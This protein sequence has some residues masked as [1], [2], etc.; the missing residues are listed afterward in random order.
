MRARAHLLRY[1][2]NKALKNK[3]LLIK[4]FIV[5]TL[6]LAGFTLGHNFLHIATGTTALAGAALLMFLDGFGH[7]HT[8]RNKKAHEAFHQVEWD[9]IFFFLGLFV[10][11]ASLEHT[12]LLAL[13]AGQITSFTE[14]D[15]TKT[16][17]TI[18]WASTFFSAF[19]NNI[20]FVATL[21]PIIESMGDTFGHGDALNPLWWSLVLG[22]CLGGNGTLIGA[23]ANVMVASFA[24]RS[25]NPISFMKY[26]VYGL[27]LTILTII[28]ANIYLMIM[29]F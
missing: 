16:G 28:I 14:G 8:E 9:T 29:Y 4:S 12:G 18:L 22:A 26:L 19:I 20:P 11:V 21:I 1:E 27:P 13:A 23:S 3:S 25:G 5:L 15:F 24:D 7:T 17:I 6:V 2:A 10:V